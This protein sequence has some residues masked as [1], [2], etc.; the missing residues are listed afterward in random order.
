MWTSSTPCTF[1]CVTGRPQP[2]S[3]KT[4]QCLSGVLRRLADNVRGL[5]AIADG[6]G[7]EWDSRAREAVTALREEGMARG[8]HRPSSSGTGC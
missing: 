3:I 6:C 8:A 5:L 4:R 7:E 2:T 1:S